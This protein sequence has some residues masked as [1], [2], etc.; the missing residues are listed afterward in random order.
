M[1][2]LAAAALLYYCEVLR[3]LQRARRRAT[4]NKRTKNTSRISHDCEL[5]RVSFYSRFVLRNNEAVYTKRPA[6]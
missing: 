3:M 6:L 4:M 2:K 1:R 5:S